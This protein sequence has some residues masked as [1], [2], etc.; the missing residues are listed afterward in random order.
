MRKPTKL[1]AAALAG[2]LLVTG[3]TIGATVQGGP[4]DASSDVKAAFEEDLRET[5]Q[6]ERERLTR[7]VEY[8]ETVQV[9][10]YA[11]AVHFRQWVEALRQAQAAEAAAAAQ[12]ESSGSGGGGGGGCNGDLACIR[13]CESGGNY[14]ATS[15]SGTYRGAYQFDQQ[16]WESVGGSGDPAQ[17]S[18]EEQDAR[19]AQLAS[20]RGSSPW[21]NCG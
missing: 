16:T 18:P 4:A 20:S 19:A 1:A 12:A 2:G 9:A 15:S 3:G 5:V 7:V 8:V 13:S 21:P 11:D 17:A 14:G 6:A 10:E